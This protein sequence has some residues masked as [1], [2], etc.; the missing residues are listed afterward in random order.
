MSR[1]PIIVIAA[2]HDIGV[3]NHFE[4][5]ALSKTYALAVAAGGAIPVLAVAETIPEA[6]AAQC[7]GLVLTGG[8]PV[9]ADVIASGYI[10]REEQ[11]AYTRHARDPYDIS[12]F[13]AFRQLEKPVLG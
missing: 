13:H 5:Y 10:S 3:E 2:A 4:Q 12:L 9:H 8:W 6:Y 11:T 7:D 1:K